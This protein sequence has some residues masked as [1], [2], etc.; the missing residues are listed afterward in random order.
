MQYVTEP[1]EGERQNVKWYWLAF[2][3]NP[4]SGSLDFEDLSA[5]TR[6]LIRLLVS[7][8]FDQ[9]NVMLVEHPEDS[10][11]RGLLIKLLDILRGYSDQSQL[12]LSSHSSVVFNTL[13]SNG[14]PIADDGGQ[15]N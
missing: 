15:H 2:E 7:L 14:D 6:R 13:R 8:I 12:I 4:H 10:I 3:P 5:G 11:H 9:S 1:A